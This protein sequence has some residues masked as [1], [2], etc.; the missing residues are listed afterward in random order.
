[1]QEQ[2][3]KHAKS[4]GERKREWQRKETMIHQNLE[5]LNNNGMKTGT[6]DMQMEDLFIGNIPYGFK[7]QQKLLIT[8][9]QPNII[10]ARGKA[11]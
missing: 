2:T 8:V 7:V 9:M 3:I 10:T 5:T 11:V 6:E 4:S 1:P